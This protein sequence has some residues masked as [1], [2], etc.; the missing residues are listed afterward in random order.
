M[1][2]TDKTSLAIHEIR[3][4][5]YAELYFNHTKDKLGSDHTWPNVSVELSHR[6]ST[7]YMAYARK[8]SSSIYLNIGFIL[9][10]LVY[11]SV[12]LQF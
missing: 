12:N 10:K 6:P 7:K 3:Q 2:I 9:N 11:L 8:F 4:N 5:A 1:L